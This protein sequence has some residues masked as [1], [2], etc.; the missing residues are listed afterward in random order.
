MTEALFIQ[1][2]AVHKQAV[3]LTRRNSN[4]LHKENQFMHKIIGNLG[5]VFCT[6][7]LPVGKMECDIQLTSNSYSGIVTSV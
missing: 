5:I 1:S 7:I 4:L 2:L 3:H 6:T